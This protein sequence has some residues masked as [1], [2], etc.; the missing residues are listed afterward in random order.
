MAEDIKSKK[1]TSAEV[2]KSFSTYGLLIP[3]TICSLLK[4]KVPPKELQKAMLDEQSVYYILCK[5][6]IQ[7]MVNGIILAQIKSYQLFMQKR[8]IDCYVNTA[9]TITEAEKMEEEPIINP[10]V[11]EMKETF[12]QHVET[13]KP[14]EQQYFDVI[15]DTSSFLK[16]FVAKNK[17]KH[18]QLQTA[19]PE[20][21]DKC[22]AF[23]EQG[24]MVEGQLLL[25]RT[26][27]R[28]H[29]IDIADL[30]M[31]IGG[32]GVDELEDLEQRAELAFFQ[33]FGEGR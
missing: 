16:K 3:Q 4:L 2:L 12:I 5:A 1:N 7:N 24:K 31:K 28:E 10:T 14:F 23:V 6:P 29:A 21:K 13:T 25:E 27:W 26:R 32:F 33:S 8:L 30:I 19:R 20:F 9:P 17:D 22:D 15:A 11:E 18:G